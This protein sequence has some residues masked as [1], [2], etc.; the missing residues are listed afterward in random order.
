M[1]TILERFEELHPTSRRLHERAARVFPD[2][3]THDT[4]Y[5]PPFSIY[6]ER[7][8]GPRKWDVDGNEIIDYVMGHG[9]LLLGH[10][11]PSVKAAVREQLD[12]GTHYGASNEL[13]IRWAE[14][15]QQLIPSAEVVRFTSSGTE[16]TMMAVRLA[17]AF[18]ER[19][20]LVRFR[21]HFHGWNDNVVGAP[22]REGVHPHAPGVPDETLSNVIVIPQNEPDALRRTLR[23][24]EV[25]AVILEPTGAL[26]GTVPLRADDLLTIREET[27]SSGSVL[28]FDEVVSGFRVSPGGVQSLTGITPD[29]TTLAKILAGGLPGG[30]VVGRS[31]IMS[32]MEFQ[33]ETSGDRVAHPGTFNASLTSAAAGEATLAVVANGL[34]HERIKNLGMDLVRDLNE[35]LVRQ[36]VRGFVYGVLPCFHIVLGHDRPELE[37]GVFWPISED[38]HP[39]TIPRHL[40]QALKRA[41]LNHGVDLW[42]LNRGLL[43][44]SHGKREIEHTIEAFERSIFEMSQEMSI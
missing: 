26:W 8:D 12:R 32:L 27:R 40:A 3:V 33:G 9:A 18:T 16:A 6:V 30:A 42:G 17:R 7:A 41:L 15:V 29:L 14:R 39:P 31:E 44:T 19:K 23:E 37:N 4:R 38:V 43:S 25:A 24:N 36:R 20:T 2:G 21:H 22:D 28:I 10:N 5:L 13:E 11:D 34:A 35:V 1:T